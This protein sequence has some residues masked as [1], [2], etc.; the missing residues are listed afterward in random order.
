MSKWKI[1]IMLLLQVTDRSLFQF[2][3]IFLRMPLIMQV[4]KPSSKLYCIMKINH[5]V[6]SCF[7]IMESELQKSIFREYL[8][9]STGLIQGVQGKVVERDSG[10]LSLNMQFLYIKERFQ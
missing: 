2:S 6:T 3:R 4:I 7:P 1:L 9:D 5:F 10:W 8:R